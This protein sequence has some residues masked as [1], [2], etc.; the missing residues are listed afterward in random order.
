MTAPPPTL[1]ASLRALPRAA[2]VLFFGTFLNK[3]GSFVIPFLTLYLTRLGYPLSA[4]AEALGAYGVGN[5]LASLLGG[6]LADRFGRRPTIVLSMFS[7]AAAMMLLSQ[8]RTLPAIIACAAL[9]GLTGELYRPASSA[10]LADLVPAGQRVTAYSALR[11]SFNAGWAFGPAIAGFLAGRG[12]FWLFAG[13]AFT[14]VLFGAVA[15]FALPRGDRH[16]GGAASW[17]D[18]GRALRRERVLPRVLGASFLIALIFFQANSTFGLHVLHR[19]YS[20]STYGAIISLNGAMIVLFE[21]PLTT[22]TRRFPAPKVMALGYLLAGFGFALN[23]LAYSIPAFV[24]CMAVFTLGEMLAMPVTSAYIAD[25][26]PATMRG[27]YMGVYGL[28]W[29][30]ALIVGPGFGMALLAAG[31]AELW[32]ACAALG[33]GAAA[34]VFTLGG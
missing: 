17:A 27:R 9:A 14:S 5:L 19:G 13:D 25:R 1:S 23:G 30:L 3:F 15:L 6:Q 31:P 10:L 16:P 28:N 29:T 12:Y 22:V 26:A 18:L 2:W 24:A 11:M 34:L 33:V 8:A 20:A 4:A 32:T 7:G 21:L